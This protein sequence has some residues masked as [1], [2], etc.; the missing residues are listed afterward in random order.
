MATEVR[1][2]GR[3][4][5]RPEDICTVEGISLRA[6]QRNY[7]ALKDALKLGKK[8]FP[9]LYQYADDQKIGIPQLCGSLKLQFE[10]VK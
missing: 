4:K 5:L 3:I 10:V 8:Q 6:A 7:Q 1:I 2:I 9:T